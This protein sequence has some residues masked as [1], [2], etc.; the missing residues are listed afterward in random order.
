MKNY[1]G[2]MVLGALVLSSCSSGLK[3]GDCVTSIKKT[4]PDGCQVFYLGKLAETE[5]AVVNLYCPARGEEPTLSLPA[6]VEF[7]ELK[8]AKCIFK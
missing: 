3:S 7:S 6:I 1:K 2:I 8:K 5:L 4:I